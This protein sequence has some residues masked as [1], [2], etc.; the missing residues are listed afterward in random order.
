MID[1]QFRKIGIA[2]LNNPILIEGFPGIGLV[3]TLA[4]GY[5]IKKFKMDLIGYIYSNKF[6]AV[7]AVHEGVPL[8]AVRIYAS[9]KHDLL[10]LISEFVIPTAI[11]PYVGEGLIEYSKRKNVK[12]VLSLGS[13][14]IDATLNQLPER[15]H[16][17][18][19]S[20]DQIFAIANTEKHRA[21][22]SKMSRIK[23][24]KEGASS[25]V[26]AYLLVE[27]TYASLPVIS[28][29]APTTKRTLDI[30]ATIR[31]LDAVTRITGLNID[32]E[33]LKEDA[34]KVEQTIK[35]IISN[36]KKAHLEYKKVDQQ[37]NFQSDSLDKMYG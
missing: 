5:L 1:V 19:A 27:G 24:I 11:V 26:S 36:A 20:E 3:G 6:P 10:V 35:S 32:L 34:I 13:V 8:P 33:E 31:V 21:L 28:L 37:N 15:K 30:V 12:L 14:A 4:T 2:N 29:L 17:E 23:I 18:E 16:N 25:G 22:L 9:E 7:S